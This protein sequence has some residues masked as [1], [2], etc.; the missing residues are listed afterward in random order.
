MKTMRT[1][2]WILFT[3]LVLQAAPAAAQSLLS[4]AD[5]EQL[6]EAIR[7][8]G[9][10]ARLEKD[11]TGDPLISSSASGGEFQIEFYGCTRNRD[12]KT[13]RFAAGY[14]LQDGATLEKVNEWN[15]DKRFASAYLDDEDDPWLQMD[16]NTE[17][18]I[19]RQ[20]FETSMDIW[21]SLKG[22]FET[23]VGFRR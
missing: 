22:Q 13:L 2:F 4:A 16:V 20:A 6:A 17:G 18:G 12:C 11:G 10:Q 7:E 21:Q 3:G 8:F 1:V 9:Y 19:S 23:F 5:P 14:D 15:V